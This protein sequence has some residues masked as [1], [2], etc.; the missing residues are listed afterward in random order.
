MTLY[1]EALFNG[2]RD[3]YEQKFLFPIGPDYQ[4]H[5]TLR[6]PVEIRKS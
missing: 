6:N 5:G 1:T 4:E 3:N 2:R